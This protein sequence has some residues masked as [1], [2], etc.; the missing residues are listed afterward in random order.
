MAV[1]GAMAVEIAKL[2]QRQIIPGKTDAQAAGVSG[3]ARPG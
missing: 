2:G 1:A 3:L